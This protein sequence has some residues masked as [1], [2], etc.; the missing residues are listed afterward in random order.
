[1]KSKILIKIKWFY[2]Y[3]NAFV[4]WFVVYNTYFGWN[5]KPINDVEKTMD[6]VTICLAYFILGNFIN[7]VLAYIH[8]KMTKEL[9]ELNRKL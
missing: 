4:V 7:I 8:F 6:T 2:R 9:N 1:M 3:V 5:E